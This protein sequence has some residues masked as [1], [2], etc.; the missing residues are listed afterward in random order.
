MQGDVRVGYASTI[1][2]NCELR[3]RIDIGRYVQLG[4]SI[5]V[6]ARDH[7]KTNLSNYV[8][9]LLFDGELK[10]LQ[11]DEPVRIGNDA[12]IGG[13]ATILKGVEI[14]DGA[15]VGG[16]SVVTRSIPPYA[17]AVGVPAK[18]VGYRFD[19]PLIDALLGIG[20][21]NYPAEALAGV[22]DAFF[23]NLK[24]LPEQEALA[25]LQ[26]SREVL[27]G[28]ARLPESSRFASAP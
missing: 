17:I 19:K 8:N 5:L 21:W 3:G 7:P 27:S 15:V 1:S 12:W 28:R 4:P 9:N 16:G 23:V 18:V 11:V 20:W 14:G 2:H 10:S 22:K 24:E 6:V 26:R 13:H 25:L